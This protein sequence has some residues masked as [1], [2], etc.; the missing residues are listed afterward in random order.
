MHLTSIKTRARL[1]K[2]E[3]N[4]NRIKLNVTVLEN[5]HAFN[6]KLKLKQEKKFSNSVQKLKTLTV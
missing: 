1:L 6:L 5:D 4:L 3:E 2:Q